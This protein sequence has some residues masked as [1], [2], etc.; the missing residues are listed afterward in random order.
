MSNT[1]VVLL[2]AMVVFEIASQGNGL[3]SAGEKLLFI[4]AFCALLLDLTR[5][6][7]FSIPGGKS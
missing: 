7:N 3:S 1:L 5:A 6:I 4:S 2:L